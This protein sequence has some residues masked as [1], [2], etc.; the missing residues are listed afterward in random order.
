MIPSNWTPYHR[1]SDDELVGYLIDGSPQRVPVNLAGYPLAEAAEL[2]AA[3]AVLESTGLASLD[4]VWLWRTEDD[5]MEVRILSAYPGR[6][7]VVETEY[8]YFGP[9]STRHELTLPADLKPSRRP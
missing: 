4:Q 1:D 6:I 7:V 3:Q 2:G 5:E 9:D 8:G